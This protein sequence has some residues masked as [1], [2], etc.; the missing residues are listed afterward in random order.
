MDI[1]Q[2]LHDSNVMIV[3]K[4]IIVLNPSQYISISQFTPGRVP[5]NETLDCLNA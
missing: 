4:I 5:L 1:D 2:S 3:L